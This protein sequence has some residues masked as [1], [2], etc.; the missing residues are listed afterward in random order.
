MQKYLFYQYIILKII[1]TYQSRKK[2]Y[3]LIPVR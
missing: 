1:N 3:F 2:M